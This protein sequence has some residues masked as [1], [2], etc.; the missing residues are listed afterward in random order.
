MTLNDPLANVLSFMNNYEKLGKKEVETKN[1]S[2]VIRA[3]LKIMQDEGFIGGHEEI[4]DGKGNILKINLIGSLNK[5]GVIKPRFR[6]QVKDY[7]KY[8]KRFLP[9]MNFGVLIVSTNKGLMTNKEAK[10]K[11]LGG[12][13]ISYVY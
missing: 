1:N 3:V 8:E 5:C 7:E 11:Q 10:E 4:E 6:I 12:T 9:A 13:L 2:K